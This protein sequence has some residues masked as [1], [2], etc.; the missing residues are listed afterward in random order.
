M[1]EG[2][3]PRIGPGGVREIGWVNSGIVKLAGVAVGGDPPH[4]FSTLA[5]HRRL[6]R[7]WLRF[8]GALMPGGRLPREDTELLILRVAHNSG[9]DYEWGHH[10]RLA[11]DAGLTEQE[12]ARVRGG[13]CAPGWSDRRAALLS[14]ADELHLD[15][16]IGDELWGRLRG[17]L[18]DPELIELCML[19]GHYEMLAM[20]LNS[21]AVEPDPIADHR[22]ALA[23]RMLGARRRRLGKTEAKWPSRI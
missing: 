20:T 10:E 8:A 21:L 13:A 1:E 16:R 7:R 6:F 15:R 23:T 22:S 3:I 12:I 5:R 4:I 19:V 18:D 11:R 9:C 2:Q 14:A 17:M